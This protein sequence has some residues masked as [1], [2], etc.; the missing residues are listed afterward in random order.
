MVI[1]LG[2]IPLWIVQSMA[3]RNLLTLLPNPSDITA[4]VAYTELTV[5]G[6]MWIPNLT[7][8]DASFILPVAL[9]VV[10]L[11]IIECQTRMRTRP[12]GRIQKITTNFFRGLSVLMVPVACSVPSGL[13]FYW[14]LSSIYGLGQCLLIMSP[15]F[16][17]IVGIPKMPSEVDQPYRRIYQSF[18]NKSKKV[19]DEKL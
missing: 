4:Q 1:L 6:F 5:G 14:F 15:R 9:G 12:P 3:I 18:F 10:N 19:T 7:Q 16:K 8:V 2:Q 13:S 11:T 17:R